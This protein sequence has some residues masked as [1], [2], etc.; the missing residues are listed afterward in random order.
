MLTTGN[1]HKGPYDVAEKGE[2]LVDVS[3][4]LQLFAFCLRMLL[5]LRTC[6]IDQVQPRIP[7]LH[8][9]VLLLL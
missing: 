3:S 8:D 1:F 9:A 7:R 2:R 6:E 5:P 4:F